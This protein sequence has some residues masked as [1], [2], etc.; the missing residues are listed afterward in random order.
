M[1][2]QE[3]QDNSAAGG[4]VAEETEEKFEANVKKVN[5][6]IEEVTEELEEMSQQVEKLE[7][8]KLKE[9]ETLWDVKKAEVPPA[10]KGAQD[11]EPEPAKEAPTDSR[12][13]AIRTTVGKEGTVADFIS[14]RV[15]QEKLVVRSVIAPAALKGYVILE[16]PDKGEVSKAVLNIQHVRGLIAGEVQFDEIIHYLE[17]KAAK[18]IPEKALVELISGPFKGEKAKVVRVDKSKDSITVELIEATVPIPLTV[19]MDAVR[20][21]AASTDVLEDKKLIAQEE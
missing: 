17:A 8:P 14:N 2:E 6:E 19:K 18:E 3:N 11:E 12:L 5:K 7:L 13:Y 4:T 20:V 10:P 1:S 15:K 21:L 16:S 9:S